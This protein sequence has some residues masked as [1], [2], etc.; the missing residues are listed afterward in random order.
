MALGRDPDFLFDNDEK[1]W[2]QMFFGFKCL[3]KNEFLSL[4]KNVKLILTT[5]LANRFSQQLKELGFSNT[6]AVSFERCE[7]RIRSIV[8]LKDKKYQQKKTSLQLRD[9]RGNWCYI[10]GASRGIGAFIAETLANYGV[11]L[12]VQAR[13]YKSLSKVSKT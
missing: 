5:R 11:N 8:K 9:L 4:S 6:Y 12:V 1:K 2:G 13:S 10:S 3:S 7:S